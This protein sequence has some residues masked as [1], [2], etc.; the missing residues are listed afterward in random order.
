MALYKYPGVTKSEDV[1]FDKEFSPGNKAEWHGIY[2][3]KNCGD[4]I[5]I[6]EGHVLPPQNHH[7]HA[8]AS[9]IIWR[10]FVY[11]QQKK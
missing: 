5:A 2:K 3:C 7:Q 9:P 8:N 10:L 4:E 6:A 11:S 1:A